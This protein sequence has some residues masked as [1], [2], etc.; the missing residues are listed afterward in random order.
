MAQTYCRAANS[1]S[2]FLNNNDIDVSRLNKDIIA[3]YN[4]W[5]VTRGVVRNTISFYMRVLRSAYNKAAEEGYCRRQDIFKNVYTGVDKTV[6]RAVDENTILRLSQL[7]LSAKPHLAFARDLFM[8]SYF[9]RGM[10]FVDMAYLKKTSINNNIISYI[11]KKTGQRLMVRIEPP[12]SALIEKYKCSS[13]EYIFPI[14][15]TENSEH[16]YSQYQSSLSKYNKHLK[17]L[18]DMLGSTAHLTSYTPRHSWASS[19]QKHH[20]PI[21]II[22][23]GMGHSSEAT[24]RIYLESLDNS[25]IDQANN[26]I[27]SSIIFP[28]SS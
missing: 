16:A 5:L 12:I 6:K 4:T 10:A 14:I 7:N 20:V 22:S 18:T 28:I 17:T 26:K 23:A 24:T 19:A 11:R 3:N 9:T 13:S 15:Q 21:S 25:L 8:F 2:T 27:I 1:F